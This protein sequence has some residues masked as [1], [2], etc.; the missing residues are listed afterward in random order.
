MCEPWF[1]IP[2]VTEW[3]ITAGGRD[4]IIEAT[5]IEKVRV[6]I[7]DTPSIL[8]SHP[9][10]MT[11]MNQYDNYVAGLEQEEMEKAKQT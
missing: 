7:R 2:L 5:N 11:A 9:D 1:E 8:G 4:T 6:D 10:I 3:K